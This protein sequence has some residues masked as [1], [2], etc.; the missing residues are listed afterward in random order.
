MFIT[1]KGQ[2]T[3]PQK[4]REEFGLLPYTEIEFEKDGDRLVIRKTAESQAT[5]SKKP[6]RGD[7]LIKSLA[8]KGSVDLRMNTDEIMLWLRGE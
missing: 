8:G 7:M 1:S 5:K 2:V 3:I 6:S 4:F